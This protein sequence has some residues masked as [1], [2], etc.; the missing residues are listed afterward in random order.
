M[1]NKTKATLQNV[2]IIATIVLISAILLKLSLKDDRIK[3]A[4]ASASAAGANQSIVNP[5]SQIAVDFKEDLANS[6]GTFQDVLSE[7][8]LETKSIANA[9]EPFW[10]A[11]RTTDDTLVT[12]ALLASDTI[13]SGTSGVSEPIDYGG[14]GTTGATF[15]DQSSTG[16]TALASGV[17]TVDSSGG[18]SSG[19]GT[20][21]KPAASDD[22]T[23]KDSTSGGGSIDAVPDDQNIAS[24]IVLSSLERLLQDEVDISGA[25]EAEI[26]CAKNEYES[27]QIIVVNPSDTT[28]S[29]IDLKAGNWHFADAPGE[30]APELTLYREH[31]V[32]ID[33]PSYNLKSKLGMYPDALIPFIDPYTGKEIVSA[34]Y[35]AKNQDVGPHK[36]QGYW[37]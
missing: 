17:G 13:N 14:N 22:G 28:I 26:F 15:G 16:T 24:V 31:Y 30:G 5:S 2:G 36:N 32:K 9:L 8:D 4:P 33:Q 1:I 23:S 18:D 6:V 3:I 37:V 20:T 19:S 34:K 7:S 21:N 27:F 11:S 35:L 10:T 29:Q 12:D 25:K